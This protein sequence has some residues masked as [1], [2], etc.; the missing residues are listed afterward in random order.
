[1][2]RVPLTAPAEE[3]LVVKTASAESPRDFA[4]ISSRDGLIDTLLLRLRHCPC[5]IPNVE[6]V[7][8]CEWTSD[9]TSP[10]G[11]NSTHKHIVINQTTA[12]NCLASS[13]LQLH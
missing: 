5:P 4:R 2:R 7:E 13:S 10:E 1:M 6:K 11:R 8:Q 9:R 12:N 3:L